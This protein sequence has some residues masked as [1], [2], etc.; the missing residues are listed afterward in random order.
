MKVLSQFRESNVIECPRYLAARFNEF[1]FNTL[2]ITTVKHTNT[3]ITVIFL[4]IANEIS[5]CFV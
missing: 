4:Y 1:V 2:D 5:K 3:R